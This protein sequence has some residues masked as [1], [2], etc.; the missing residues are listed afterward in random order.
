LLQ[1][2]LFV[3]DVCFYSGYDAPLLIG[4]KGYDPNTASQ[5]PGYD[6]DY[7]NSEIL[8]GR[9][10]VREGRITLPDGMSYALL[11]LPDREDMPLEVAEKLEELVR[12]GATLVGPRPLRTPGLLDPDVR[13]HRD[14]D[15]RLV[16]LAG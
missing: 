2:G 4:N 11:V 5:G 1:K 14:R 8:L 16:E 15:T 7:I 10:T 12:N 13:V 3:A 6:Y 9:A